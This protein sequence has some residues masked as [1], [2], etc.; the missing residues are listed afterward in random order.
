MALW[1]IA[2]VA[3]VA[4]AAWVWYRRSSALRH[5]R[6][7][8]DAVRWCRRHGST[9]DDLLEAAQ[10]ELQDA[11]A[12]ER[13]RLAGRFQELFDALDDKGGAHAYA[14]TVLRSACAL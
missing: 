2:P 4:G 6:T 5:I 3:P 1:Y 7:A 12:D 9:P 8:D 14:L 10:R 13:A 11:P